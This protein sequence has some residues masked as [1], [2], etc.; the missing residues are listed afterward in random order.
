[1]TSKKQLL[2]AYGLAIHLLLIGIICYAA[3][4]V[5]TPVRPIR[6]MYQTKAG[7]VLFDHQ[8]HSSINGYAL[9]CYDCHHHPSGDKKAL[10]ACGQCH[11]ASVKNGSQPARCLDCHDK[12]KIKDTKMISKADAFHQQCIGCHE[13]FGKGPQFGS[14]N[15][16]KCHVR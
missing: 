14:Q 6:I 10:V 8:A 4:P 13:Q 5:K 3:F 12:S 2:F 7:K 11:K 15:C 16:N 9:S 1:M